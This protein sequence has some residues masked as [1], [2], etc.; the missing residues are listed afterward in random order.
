MKIRLLSDLH[1]EFEN[2]GPIR[3]GGEDLVVLAGDIHTGVLAVEWGLKTF[4]DIPVVLVA[5]N[6][7]YFGG[8]FMMTLNEMRMAAADTNVH[9]LE[10][11]A[12]VV[13][14]VRFIG[15]TLWTDFSLFGTPSFSLGYAQE[16]MSDFSVILDGPADA[17]VKLTPERTVERFHESM[18]AIKRLVE[19]PFAGKTVV[20]THHLPSPACVDPRFKGDKCNAA[21]ASNLD[22]FIEQHPQIG[23]WMHGHT[24]ASVEVMVG[25]TR[26]LCNP[27]GYPMGGKRENRRFEEEFVLH[28]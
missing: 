27:G 4:P 21:F 1:V 26:V 23:C 19:E 17:F 7:E 11:D 18:A 10:N 3:Q 6:H 12:V 15:A 16:A 20:V 13:G 2:L 28:L 5:G 8:H 25:A 24:H 22:T 14:N 9:F